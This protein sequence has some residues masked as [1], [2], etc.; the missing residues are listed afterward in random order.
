M[1]GLRS[2]DYCMHN[3]RATRA[4]ADTAKRGKGSDYERLA[5]SAGTTGCN[6]GPRAHSALTVFCC[7]ISAQ[8][9]DR[10]RLKGERRRPGIPGHERQRRGIN[11]DCR[12]QRRCERHLLQCFPYN[13]VV[14]S[15]IINPSYSHASPPR[16]WARQSRRNLRRL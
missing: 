6:R 5:L 12:P 15:N 3:T 13:I 8:V 7:C 2:T 4:P 10:R 11:K 1:L 14:M 16:S 9:E